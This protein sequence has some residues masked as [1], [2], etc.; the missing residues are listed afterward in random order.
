MP[1]SKMW[2][3]SSSDNYIKDKLRNLISHYGWVYGRLAFLTLFICTLCSRLPAF[4]PPRSCWYLY[5]LKPVTPY[6]MWGSTYHSLKTAALCKAENAQLIE[7][8]CLLLYYIYD[9]YYKY[10]IILYYYI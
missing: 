4:P 5:F 2:N 9:I 8:S 6:N 7:N 1:F 10:Y 3:F